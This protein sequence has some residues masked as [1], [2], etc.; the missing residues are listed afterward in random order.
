MI[1]ENIYDAGTAAKNR[2]IDVLRESVIKTLDSVGKSLYETK[3]CEKTSLEK[4]AKL[5][6]EYV[7]ECAGTGNIDLIAEAG[8]F[9]RN[10]VLLA[11]SYSYMKQPLNEW[12]AQ[13][14]DTYDP[15]DQPI[16]PAIGM[17]PRVQVSSVRPYISKAKNILKNG[18][19]YADRSYSAGDLLEEAPVRII[20]IEDTYSR[21]IRD[22][23][24]EVDAEQGIYAIPMG[25]ASYYRN[26]EYSPN[27]TY[28]FVYNPENGNG[29]I[30]IRANKHISKG[31]EI[32]VT[33]S[34]KCF[35]EPNYDRF[36]TKSNSMREIS[37]SNFRFQ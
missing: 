34:Q 9:E 12:L 7:N 25:Y 28:S 37:V 23:S 6:E 18:G 20:H 15:D 2:G 16:T 33:R 5:V 27:A 13:G 32:T 35:R 3:T 24:F 22:L 11:D 8:A 14:F 4:A 31:D 26:D 1:V 29:H 19:M 30:M 17:K 21:P 10:F 36:G